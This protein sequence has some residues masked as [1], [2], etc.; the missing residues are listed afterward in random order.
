MGR[1]RG[2]CG[3]PR[4]LGHEP[5]GSARGDGDVWPARTNGTELR[6]V[7]GNFLFSTGA[8]EFAGRHTAGH[9]DLPMMGTTITVD[10]AEVVRDGVVV[11]SPST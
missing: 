1:P 2:V 3:Q 5:A 7:A 11:A 10:G 9:F 6:A 4:R 8:N